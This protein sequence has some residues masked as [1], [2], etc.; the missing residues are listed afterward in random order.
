MPEN[1]HFHPNLV[2]AYLSL[3]YL[4]LADNL[5]GPLFPS[6]LERFG[7]S[8]QQGAWYFAASSVMSFLGA[9]LVPWLVKRLGYKRALFVSI[10]LMVTSQVVAAIAP[11]FSVFVLSSVL[12][13]L[14]I[15]FLGVIQ[16]VM[17]LVS[18]EG[19]VRA[20]LSGGLHTKYALASLS[21]PL[22]V[23]FFAW[24]QLPLQS[25]FWVTSVFGIV[26]LFAV[27]RVPQFTE[28]TDRL[29]PPTGA[30]SLSP[31]ILYFAAMLSLY[32]VAE[33]VMSSRL[34]QF[35]HQSLGWSIS[36]SSTLAFQFFVGMF[37][38]RLGLALVRISFSAPKVLRG[39]LFLALV[40][41]VL[42]TFHHPL[43]F[44]FL[45]IVMG[46]IYPLTVTAISETFPQQIQAAT[47]AAVVGSGLLV[48]V[49]H[50]GVGVLTDAYGVKMALLVT[51]VCC[52]VVFVLNLLYPVIFRSH[53][54]V[55][56]RSV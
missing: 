10:L 17:V 45:G 37:I 23:S 48:L 20:R 56:G 40:L 49:M 14:S 38:G 26:I 24:A 19:A 47:T 44:I 16:N 41:S 29:A 13:G 31:A 36:E 53:N 7:L 55:D 28:P 22:L 4:G 39:A 9:A 30:R 51:P 15:G 54:E 11:N 42:A 52:L 8:S 1:K 43:W 46:P 12:I 27:S 34:S 5:R 3:F 33:I 50:L 25:S 18:G 21:A 32:V 35:A 6:L 2:F